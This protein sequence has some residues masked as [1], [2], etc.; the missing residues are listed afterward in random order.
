ML[1]NASRFPQ[2]ADRLQQGLVNTLLMGRAMVH[3][4]GLGTQRPFQFSNGTSFLDTQKLF[5]DATGLGGNFGTAVTALAPDLDRAVLGS[6]RDALQP[7]DGPQH[8]AQAL[9]RRCSARP[10]PTASRATSCWR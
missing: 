7:D 8:A 1:R 6:T 10:T 2:F 4:K 3:P 5:L 9:R